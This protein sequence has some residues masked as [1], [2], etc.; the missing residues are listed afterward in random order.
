MLLSAFIFLFTHEAGVFA[1][2]C[3]LENTGICVERVADQPRAAQQCMPYQSNVLLH[4]SL[5]ELTY[6]RLRGM[7][8]FVSQLTNLQHSWSS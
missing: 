7:S 3:S 5:H 6:V 2:G 8:R 4:V 1:R